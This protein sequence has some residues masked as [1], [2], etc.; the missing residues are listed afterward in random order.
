MIAQWSRTVRNH[1]RSQRVFAIITETS[2]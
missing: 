1:A 2:D